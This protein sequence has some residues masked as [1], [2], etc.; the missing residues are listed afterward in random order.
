MN[1][2]LCM[3]HYPHNDI[4]KGKMP[5]HISGVPRSADFEK[6][7]A[8]GNKEEQSWARPPAGWAK[9]NKDGAFVAADG[10][11]GSG[12]VLRDDTCGIIFT[13]CRGSFPCDNALQAELAACREG[14]ALALE[15]T[16]CP[17]IIEMDRAEAVSMLQSVSQDRSS[18]M[19]CIRDIKALME[20]GREMEI[21]LISRSQNIVS[22]ALAAYGGSLPRTAVWLGSG[23]EE[24]VTLC[25]N[26]IMRP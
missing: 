4:A 7:P 12:M 24:I 9:L 20:N 26:D 14:V 16:S 6:Q 1:S 15:R 17:I 22:H 5:M 23:T 2:L 25:M 19:A 21:K 13:A 8:K 3:Q 10:S 18:S 11:T